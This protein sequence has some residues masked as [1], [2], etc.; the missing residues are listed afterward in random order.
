MGL[1]ANLSVPGPVV[2]TWDTNSEH[3]RI[4]GDFRAKP[5][6][7]GGDWAGVLHPGQSISYHSLPLTMQTPNRNW[8]AVRWSAI[9][10]FRL[11]RRPDVL[12]AALDLRYP[13]RSLR[14]C[15]CAIGA[16][17]RAKR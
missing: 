7:W 5:D 17:L 8:D 14:H 12:P 3:V 4:Y 16:P 15:W 2:E 1:D 11:R 10:Q 6:L 13:Y 9:N